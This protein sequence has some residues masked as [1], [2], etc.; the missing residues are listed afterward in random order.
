MSYLIK[1]CAR[2]CVR[3]RL[4]VWSLFKIARGKTQILNLVCIIKIHA[5]LSSWNVLDHLE[6]LKCFWSRVQK[7]RMTEGIKRLN[8]QKTGW[9]FM[10]RSLTGAVKSVSPLFFF[11]NKHL[12][13]KGVLVWVC[14]ST[15]GR[16]RPA[17]QMCLDLLCP[18]SVKV[19]I[20]SSLQSLEI[21]DFLSGLQIHGGGGDGAYSELV[22]SS[23]QRQIFS[24]TFNLL[25]VCLFI[26]LKSLL[27]DEAADCNN[28]RASTVYCHESAHRNSL[29]LYFCEIL[30]PFL[31]I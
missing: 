23:N 6:H 15:S 21:L 24:G 28:T 7:E 22:T 17:C 31:H 12:G 9:I 2:V 30:N 16:G 25:V 13:K 26:M 27:C 8:K 14:S 18:P 5:R 29:V 19:W 10:A 3:V 1:L 4:C 11:K 20:P